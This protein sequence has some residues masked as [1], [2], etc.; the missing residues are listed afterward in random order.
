MALI[1]RIMRD[2]AAEAEGSSR[3][4]KFTREDWEFMINHGLDRI[5]KGWTPNE[6][7]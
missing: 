7:Q 1:E 2:V 6:T 4:R 5:K 3:Q